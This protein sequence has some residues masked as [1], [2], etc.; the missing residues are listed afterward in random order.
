MSLSNTILNLLANTL[1]NSLY[2]L[3]TKLIGRK[4]LIFNILDFNKKQ[5][6]HYLN[7]KETVLVINLETVPRHIER[8]CYPANKAHK[9]TFSVHV[10]G[11]QALSSCKYT[12]GTKWNSLFGILYNSKI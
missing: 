4:S 7:D 5:I 9:L 8:W 12:V 6:V 2:T 10:R 1:N 3:P 11:F